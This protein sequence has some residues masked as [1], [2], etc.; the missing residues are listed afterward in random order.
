MQIDLVN[1][2]NYFC[3]SLYFDAIESTNVISFSFG[4]NYP[5]IYEMDGDSL[6]NVLS[7]VSKIY[8]KS[9]KKSYLHIDFKLTNY[10]T[11]YA[12][13]NITFS[14]SGVFIPMNKLISTAKKI[15]EANDIQI[16]INKNTIVVQ[17]KGKLVKDQQKSIK[18]LNENIKKF[19]VIINY[20]YKMGFE[21]ISKSLRYLGLKVHQSNQYDILKH[22]VMDAI[23]KPS[24]VFLHQS[25]LQNKDEFELILKY[26][27]LKN[28][29]IVI[30]N[31]QKDDSLENNKNFFVLRQPFTYDILIAT[32]NTCYNEQKMAKLFI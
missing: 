5:R 7:A 24:V 22:H 13:F 18:F 28:F 9:L 3:D 32:L 30:I 1:R 23:Y 25:I 21:S 26:K 14:C 20:E 10:S 6:I 2:L 17:S 27:K 31:D 19:H 11:D 12:F 15:A 4:T 8:T 16:F 29:S